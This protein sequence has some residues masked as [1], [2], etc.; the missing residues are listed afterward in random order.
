MGQCFAGSAEK[1][2]QRSHNKMA[3][4]DL[5]KRREE[6]SKE[7]KL[8]LL[9]PGESG[10]STIFKVWIERVILWS[11]QL[12]SMCITNVCICV[13][14]AHFH[15]DDSCCFLFP[16]L[17]GSI[18]FDDIF[19]FPPLV[20]QSSSLTHTQKTHQST[21]YNFFFNVM[22]DRRTWYVIDPWIIGH[23]LSTVAS[24]NSVQ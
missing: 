19:H 5:R 1:Q 6:L 16:P 15:G 20:C 12:S 23:V 21:I 24:Q 22:D 10:K 14:F 4:D 2:N 11:S 8:L 7:L 13:V 9:G 17:F 18:S 3:N